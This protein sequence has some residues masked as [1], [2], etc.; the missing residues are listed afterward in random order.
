MRFF[1]VDDEKYALDRMVRELKTAS[2]EAEIFAFSN[3]HELLEFANSIDENYATLNIVG[4]CSINTYGGSSTAQVI[5][6][7]YEFTI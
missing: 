7:N 1:V 4:K 5:I 3:P 2:P 6:D